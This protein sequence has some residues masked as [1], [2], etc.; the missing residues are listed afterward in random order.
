MDLL[1][2]D[3]PYSVSLQGN[4]YELL[5]TPDSN[6][7]IKMLVGKKHTDT[8]FPGDYTEI[9]LKLA[10]AKSAV[11]L[12]NSRAKFTG[13]KIGSESFSLRDPSWLLN[14]AKDWESEFS[15]SLGRLRMVVPV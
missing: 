5:P 11:K 12:A 2:R 1:K 9:V 6:S 8:T 15:N 3:S 10:A 4:Q 14:Q 13:V 7:S